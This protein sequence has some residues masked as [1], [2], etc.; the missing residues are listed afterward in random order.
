MVA[1][2]VWGGSC[3]IVERRGFVPRYHVCIFNE[4]EDHQCMRMLDL[5]DVIR[6]C[7]PH[8]GLVPECGTVWHQPE[9][10]NCM[11]NKAMGH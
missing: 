9:L 8:S 7:V 4:A 10:R 6:E 11:R 2:S 1:V 3:C 5:K